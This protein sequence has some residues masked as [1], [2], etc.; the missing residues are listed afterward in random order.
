MALAGLLLCGCTRDEVTAYRVPHEKDPELA[1]PDQGGG[2]GPAEDAS[3]PAA[4]AAGLAW[5]APGS[6]KEKPATQMRKAS[7]SATA[8]GV[9]CDVSV[10]SFPGDVG[11]ELANV[12]RWRG[13]IGLAP[14]AAAELE[15]AV[16]RVTVNGLQVTVVELGM[17]GD[18]GGKAILGAIVPT[19]AET[20]FL[21]A[22][23]PAQALAALRGEF[24]DF[25]GSV[26]PAGAAPMASTP[27][28][29]AQT[30]DLSWSAPASWVQG[31]SSAM[32]KASFTVATD[33]GSCE[34]SVTAFPG[35]VGGELANVNR[36]RGQVGTAA[37]AAGD[38]AGVLTRFDSN[39]LSFAVTQADS[40]DGTKSL[41]AAMVPYAGST[42]FFKLSGP[43]AAVA[44]ARGG[45][46]AFIR[47]VRAP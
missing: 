40:P 19:G 15:Q 34:V 1:A 47:S 12:N 36:W 8:A 35:D 9:E 28:P 14:L 7:Y 24:M 45:F 42:W 2:Q 11:G 13:Q 46:D 31:P 22:A 37:V 32:R 18:A 43:S 26:R 3:A 23:G 16:H 29:V 39:G 30:Q 6:W 44:K 20:Y 33:A 27:V 4:P 17:A 5:T 10:A 21:K 25:V 41:R 38:L